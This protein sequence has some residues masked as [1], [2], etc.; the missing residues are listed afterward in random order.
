MKVLHH[1]NRTLMNIQH[2]HN[3]PKIT[4][5]RKHPNLDF[6]YTVEDE[7]MNDNDY[8]GNKQNQY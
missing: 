4:Y 8:N 5:R 2:K 3:K 1:D 7:E 6:L